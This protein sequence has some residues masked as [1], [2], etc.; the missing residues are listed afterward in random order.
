[1]MSHFVP[2]TGGRG[3]SIAVFAVIVDYG[4]K[5]CAQHKQQ[6]KY[7]HCCHIAVARFPQASL[8]AEV[9]KAP[10]TLTRCMHRSVEH[11]CNS[12]AGFMHPM[13]TCEHCI[14]D[15][16]QGPAMLAI[17]RPSRPLPEQL[18]KPAI[19]RVD[20]GSPTVGGCHT[21]Y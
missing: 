14:V 8:Q 21:W 13:L 19:R 9:L 20:A 12:L 16:E 4:R 7:R 2:H 1:M 6:T 17:L 10:T 18:A 3:R 15:I 5:K 11:K